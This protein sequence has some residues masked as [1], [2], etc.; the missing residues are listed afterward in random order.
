MRRS[1]ALSKCRRPIPGHGASD[2]PLRTRNSTRVKRLKLI[3]SSGKWVATIAPYVPLA[4]IVA[5]KVLEG[6]RGPVHLHDC[7]LFARASIGIPSGKTTE[8]GAEELLRNADVAMYIAKGAFIRA[9]HARS[10]EM[11]CGSRGDQCCGRY[12]LQRGDPFPVGDDG[13]GASFVFLGSVLHSDS[14]RPGAQLAGSPTTIPVMTAK[15]TGSIPVAPTSENL[16]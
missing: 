3:A 6:F 4:G 9:R 5:D 16:V 7:E 2:T 8:E 12:G 1:Q 13:L 11:A 15:A 14:L 10:E